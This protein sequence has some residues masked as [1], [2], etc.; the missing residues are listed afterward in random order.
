[1][2]EPVRE[3]NRWF[4]SSY[5]RVVRRSRTFVVLPTCVFA[6]LLCDLVWELVRAN[7]DTSSAGAWP[8]R[9]TLLGVPSA[10][11]L[12]GAIGSLILARG[13]F[14]RSVRPSLGWSGNTHGAGTIMGS[15]AAWTVYFNNGGPGSCVV[16][17]VLY[18]ATFRTEAA[19]RTDQSTENWT[20]L[21]D[22]FNILKDKGLEKDKD[23]A[24]TAIGI[25]ATLPP[26]KSYQDAKELAA[27]STQALRVIMS[28]EVRIR[29]TDVVGDT[30]ERVL[31]CLHAAPL[32]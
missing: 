8:W 22:V 16:D 15:Q 21:R 23:Y 12:A 28:F 29:V 14:A 13:Q 9:F 7:V 4:A 2:S 19:Q 6:V 26:T 17:E 25:G 20:Y 32:P 3:T 10:A 30:H 27:F 11:A 24:L 31:R 18:R 5:Q 1:M